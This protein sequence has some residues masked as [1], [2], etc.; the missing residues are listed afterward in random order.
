MSHAKKALPLRRLAIIGVYLGLAGITVLFGCVL[1][2]SAPFDLASYAAWAGIFLVLAALGFLVRP[3]RVL[4]ARP[5]ARAAVMLGLGLSM[6]TTALLWPGRIERSARPHCRLDDFLPEFQFVEYHEAR[7]R[8]PLER[9][10]EAAQHVSLADM[11]AARVLVRLRDIASGKL[12]APPADTTPLIDLFTRPGQGSLLLDGSRA[13]EIVVGL[14]G[15]PWKD[16]PPPQVGSAAD[17]LAFNL[18]GHVRV[19]FDIRTVDE[20]SGVVRVSTETRILGNDTRAR[21]LFARYWRLIYP[22]SAIIRRVWLDAIIARAEGA[23]P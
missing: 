17:F 18:A 6:T 1:W 12:A 19:V 22:G 5:R 8:A 20:G 16:E 7:T 3:L 15:R 14:I 4:G 21:R 11:P 23:Q 10:L 13:Q 2:R 9:V